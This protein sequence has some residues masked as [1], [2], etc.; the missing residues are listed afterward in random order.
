M[1]PVQSA[2]LDALAADLG[3]VRKSLDKLADAYA[4]L[5]VI[6]E[7]QSASREAV[8]RAFRQLDAMEARIK[9]LGDGLD[10]RLKTLETSAPTNKQAAVWVDRFLSLVVG[11]VIAAVIT[12]VVVRAPARDV[13]SPPTLERPR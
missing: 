13:A 1:D 4:R 10:T 6:E 3:E 8:D 11:A 2:K 5:A 9:S 7:R 12:T